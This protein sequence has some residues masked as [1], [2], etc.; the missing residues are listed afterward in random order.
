MT[1]IPEQGME[2]TVRVYRVFFAFSSGLTR[3][4]LVN[5]PFHGIENSR[6]IVEKFVDTL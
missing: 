2:T 5:C 4:W 3:P 1:F 6:L